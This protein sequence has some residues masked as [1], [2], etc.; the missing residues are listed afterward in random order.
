[1]TAGAGPGV[2]LADVFHVRGS[3]LHYLSTDVA[4]ESHPPF[5]PSRSIALS[6]ISCVTLCETFCVAGSVRQAELAWAWL[7]VAETIIMII[8]LLAQAVRGWMEDMP[9][10]VNVP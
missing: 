10:S 2:D 5:P 1:M 3:C 9:V 7:L 4:E 6:S 8:H